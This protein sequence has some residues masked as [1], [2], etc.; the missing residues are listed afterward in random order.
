MARMIH[1]SSQSVSLDNIRKLYNMPLKTTP[2]NLFKGK[3]WSEMTPE[4][5]DLVARGAE[6]EI[7]ARPA[8]GF[9]GAIDQIALGCR[10]AQVQRFTRGAL[11]RCRSSGFHGTLRE[12]EPLFYNFVTPMSLRYFGSRGDAEDILV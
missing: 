9:R 12:T 2:Y 5:Q 6:D 3:H 11:G 10:N 4:V 8:T 7:G 1:G